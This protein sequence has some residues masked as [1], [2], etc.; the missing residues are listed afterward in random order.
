MLR[1]TPLTYFVGGTVSTG[2]GHTPISCSA[3]EMVH[4]DPP[5]GMSCASYLAEY[6]SYA[7]GSLFNP[8]S[9]AN[10][11]FCPASNTDDVLA[12]L[13]IRYEDRWR[14]FGLTLVYSV[15]NVLGAL[16]LYWLF[17]MPKKTKM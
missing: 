5:G 16:A 7:G 15:I 13:G 17:R 11:Q 4:F 3:K 1:V 10:C 9:T 8:E 12:V 6:I 14:N 2:I